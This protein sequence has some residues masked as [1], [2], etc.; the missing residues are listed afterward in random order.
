MS[1]RPSAFDITASASERFR[2]LSELSSDCTY[3]FL[4]NESGQAIIEWVSDA[5]ERIIGAPPEP[6]GTV[7]DWRRLVHRD[8]LRVL[9]ESLALALNNQPAC[10]DM[11]VLAPTGRV[12]WI[13]NRVSPVWDG[14]LR[15][16]TAL[17]GSFHDITEWKQAAAELR[18]Q[19]NNEMLLAS[20][21]HELMEHA[22]Q[23]R[24][25]RSAVDVVLRITGVTRVYLF[26]ELEDNGGGGCL[27]LVHEGTSRNVSPS[28]GIPALQRIRHASLSPG[29]L[30]CLE[31]GT[32][33]TS[34][35]EAFAPADEALFG[36]VGILSLLVLSIRVEAKLWGA[37]A[38]ADCRKRHVW[39]EGDIRILQVAASMIGNTIERK[40]VVEALRESEE[41]LRSL[42]EAT[43]DIVC[44]KDGSGRWLE[45]NPSELEVYELEGVDYRGKTDRDLAEL[46]PQFRNAFLS[47]TETDEEAWRKRA[48]TNT[49]ETVLG[50][51]RPARVFDIVK[52][53]L[54]HSDGS[55]RGLVVL[56]RDITNRKAAER[57][58]RTRLAHEQL[59]SAI[60][61]EGVVARDIDDFINRK[62]ERIG[63]ALYVSRSYVFR[64]NPHNDTADNTHEWTAPDTPAEIENLQGLP[65][66]KFPW[67]DGEM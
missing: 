22:D 48:V 37:V 3:S 58:L 25:I 55:R 33:Y 6:P 31:S 10:A 44:F 7:M 1:D 65:C 39:S 40:R 50:G 64:Y 21:S 46:R 18:E 63:K 4:I 53:P 57:E 12:R 51:S 9:R 11:R 23:Q 16:V 15:R 56:G 38:L 27:Q 49:E 60:S 30:A 14:E 35:A 41:R 5:F 19:L 47:C 17:R 34:F 67:M 52:A 29:L 54:F 26:R 62:L 20:C 43:P 2:I 13:R 42:I 45:A 59:L 32:P 28:F 8:D 66:G 24:A 36:P 61:N